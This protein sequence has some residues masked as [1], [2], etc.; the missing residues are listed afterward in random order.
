[1]TE[2]ELQFA[3]WIGNTQPMKCACVVCELTLE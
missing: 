2:P 3:I 1:V